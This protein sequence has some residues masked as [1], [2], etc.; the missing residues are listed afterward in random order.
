MTGKGNTYQQI[1]TIALTILEKTREFPTTF[2]ELSGGSAGLTVEGITENFKTIEA[3]RGAVIDHSTVLLADVMGRAIARADAGDPK[4]QVLALGLAYFEWGA[5]NPAMFGLLASALFVPRRSEVGILGM[6]RHAI[7]DLVERKLREGQ[8]R[9][10]I[11]SSL[12]LPIL[13][14]HLHCT[15][16]GISSM[17]LH[18]LPDP[19]YKGEPI[20]LGTMCGKIFALHVDQLFRS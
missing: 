17:L 12:S 13:T 11:D 15:C 6:H 3:L 2:E 19:W 1:I 18:G 8:T 7:R 14:S 16:L 9:G 5:Q 10:L 4:A 20:D